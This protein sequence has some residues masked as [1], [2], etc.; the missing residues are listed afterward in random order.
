MNLREAAKTLQ[1]A[2]RE[3]K[4]SGSGGGG[5]SAKLNS[6]KIGS[7]SSDGTRTARNRA[8]TVSSSLTVTPNTSEK[9][10]AYTGN[11]KDLSDLESVALAR[12]Q[13]RTRGMLA[14]KSFSSIRKQTMASLIIQK[15]LI[16]WWEQSRGSEAAFDLSSAPSSA[17]SRTGSYDFQQLQQQQLQ[18]KRLKQQ[19]KIA[20]MRSDSLESNQSVKSIGRVQADDEDDFELL[21]NI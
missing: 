14:R 2:W 17:A 16:K 21:S 10:A 1:L 7:S 18:E 19:A 15:S 9:S 12:L 3:K 20:L 5:V 8:D 6:P 4:K 11:I 13:A